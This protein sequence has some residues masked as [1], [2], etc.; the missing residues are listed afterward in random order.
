MRPYLLTA[1]LLALSVLYAL[2]TEQYLNTPTGLNARLENIRLAPIDDADAAAEEFPQGGLISKTYA[3]PF[4]SVELQVQS[5]Q[6][7]VFDQSGNFLYTEQNR[8]I[9]ALSIGNS[10][11]MREMQGFTVLFQTQ[12]VEGEHIR[13]L[14]DVEF[15][16]SGSTPVS[17]PTSVSPAFIA[18]YQELADN[19]ETSYLRD[20]PVSRPKML[21]ISHSNL[22]NYQTEFVKWKRS[23]G[24]DVYV[25]Y[26]SAIGTTLDQFKAFI[27]SHY[28]QYHCDYLLLLG[29]VTNQGSYTIPTAFYPSPEYAE[30]D[31][32][33]HQYTLLEGDDYFPEMLAGRLSFNDISEFM[34]MVNKSV[35][36][37]KT[38]YMANTAWMTRGLA[39]AGN[40]A[41][42]GLRPITPV[43][44][45]R[46]LRSKMLDYGYAAVDTVFYPPTYP[47]TSNIVSSINQGV[48]FV[49]YRGWGDANGWHYPSFHIPDLNTTVNGPRMPVVFSIVCNTGDF[50]NS[51]NPSFGEKWMRMGSTAQP[52]GCVAFVGPSDLHTKTRLN[53]SISSGAFRS[54][55]DYGVRGFGSSVLMGKIELY[56]NFPNDIAPNQY[57]AFYYHVYNMQADPSL[58]MW[59]LVPETINE[60]VIDGGLDF[61][62]SASHIRINAPANEGAI[63]SGTKNGTDFTYGKVQNG[64][65]ILPI[66]PDQTGSLEVTFTQPDFVPLVRT[67]TPSEP[68]GIGVVS[69]NATG[70][71]L[72]P[73]STFNAELTLK[74]FGTASA[75]ISD[76]AIGATQN[77][78]VNYQHTDFSI[79][80]GA[81]HTINFAI[82]GSSAIQP[83]EPI[84]ITLNGTNPAFSQMFQMWGGGAEFT[85]IGVNGTFPI[86][87]TS[88]VTFNIKNTGSSALLNA[89]AQV[90]SLT[91]AATF[92]AAPITLGA[93]S[94]GYE[95]SVTTNITV[96]SGAWNG[97]NLPMKLIISDN[98]YSTLVFW[99]LT[100]GTAAATSPTGP[101]EYGYFAYDSFDAGFAQTP[102]Y[103]W[104]ET[105]P[106]L[107]GSGTVWEIM[108]DGSLIVDLPFNFRF[109]GHDYNH[110]T[111]CSNG[112][113][114]LLPTD[115]E[116][117]YNCY[118]PAALGPY[119]M[120][121]PYWDDLKG[122]KTGVD[123]EGNGI[124]NN[125]RLIRW[126]DAANNRYIVQWNDAY[127]Q[128]NIDLLDEA[129][130]EK[131]QIILYPQTGRDG[132]IVFQYH[133][134]DNPGTTTNYCTVG[135]ENHTQTVGLS[136][137]HSNFYPPTA[138]P[139]QAG[140]AVK[141]TTIPP[142]SYVANDDPIL[143]APFHLAQNY[144]NP[145]N[146]ETT[147][148]F[149]SRDGGNA[150]LAIY[151][152]KGQLIRTLLDAEVN[153]GMHSAVWN[154]TDAQGT[155]VSS[156]LYLYRLDLNG[157]TQIR[158][159]LLMK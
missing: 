24:F 46:W 147:I 5:L 154:G 126:H 25:A 159:M 19:Y 139:L 152:M 14:K 36:Y 56:K 79:D 118:I 133:T 86:G 61:A 59:V 15:T 103:Q 124:F 40:Y 78:Q 83:R 62:Q 84:T 156:G 142:D 48:Q 106:A 34:T 148:S 57:V 55:F 32:D 42:G 134:V 27:L 29:D 131:F 100:A 104:I 75:S 50:A 96:A 117:F 129:S 97:R 17:L 51:V 91:E 119:A 41:E 150:R 8:G 73:N 115:M 140:L 144:P 21:I 31:A 67:L 87:Q 28:Q 58:N 39:V 69:N 80:A 26:K 105:D 53:N 2:P 65:A 7:N 12:F 4:Q 45:S 92:P 3:L 108:D 77:A 66:D 99:T 132:D 107:G 44:M 10:F 23:Q 16:L 130:L 158:K 38:P 9:D 52:N 135:I 94:V 157:Q 149:S 98:G 110:V 127:N 111:M 138:T 60:N 146:P 125:M 43:Q 112:W 13:T 116:D 95:I 123:N 143:A 68:A 70:M 76:L 22:A 93:I 82:S 20:L 122:M 35:S 109:Y 153:S 145:F 114:S 33:D 101:D 71:V 89:T 121:A 37:E 30:N 102:A 137:S 74:N 85:V 11:T 1:I 6:W 63:V 18:A 155:A 151:N 136:Y 141:F 54:I 81:T 113:I 64:F 72:H 49:S 88:S 120:I 90:V 47:G 128:Y